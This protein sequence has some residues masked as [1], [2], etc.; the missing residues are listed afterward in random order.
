[1]KNYIYCKKYLKCYAGSNI[2][3]FC[4]TADYLQK[5][6]GLAVFLMTI[7]LMSCMEG[8]EEKCRKK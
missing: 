2:K 5:N 6:T 7:V 4:V 8:L 3:G 1:M